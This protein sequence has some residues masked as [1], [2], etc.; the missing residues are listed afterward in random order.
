[1]NN[2]ENSLKRILKE[3]ENTEYQDMRILKIDTQ[4]FMNDLSVKYEENNIIKFNECY[5]I[6]FKHDENDAKIKPVSEWKINQIP[7]FIQNID[8]KLKNSFYNV[9]IDAWP[10]K[11][12]IECEDIS[13]NND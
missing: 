12:Y 5:K 9:T 13:V 6:E 8:I 2:K 4:N 1:M 11:L 3:I 10:L 7:Y